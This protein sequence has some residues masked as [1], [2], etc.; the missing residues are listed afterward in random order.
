LYDL[1]ESNKASNAALSKLARAQLEGDAVRK[2]ASEALKI[3]LELPKA[4]TAGCKAVKALLPRI[5]EHG[6]L[7]VVP[8]L[9]RLADRR[10]C[11]FLGLRD[12]FECLRSAKGKDLADA[13][14]AASERP[15]PKVGG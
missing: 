1:W 6:D 10:G 4:K 2:N 3:A 11:G 5:R 9:T 15:A 8:T 12:C 7:R 14:K 13:K